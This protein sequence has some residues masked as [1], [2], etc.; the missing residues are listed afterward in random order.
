MNLTISDHLRP[1]QF[2]DTVKM[3]TQQWFCFL[4]TEVFWI[5]NSGYCPEHRILIR[6]KILIWWGSKINLRYWFFKGKFQSKKVSFLEHQIKRRI[7]ISKNANQD[8]KTGR[9]RFSE[10]SCSWL[11]PFF[12]HDA[13]LLSLFQDMQHNR[14]FSKTCCVNGFSKISPECIFSKI[15]RRRAFSKIHLIFLT[16]PHRF[17]HAPGQQEMVE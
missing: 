7:N 14:S 16:V 1:R 4:P 13:A 10:K 17:L 8:F 12:Y 5:L 3:W 9:S 15:S 11:A 6:I 2:W